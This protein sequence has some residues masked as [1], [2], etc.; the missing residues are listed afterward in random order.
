MKPS[1]WVWAER[2]TVK[3]KGLGAVYIDFLTQ[4]HTALEPNHKQ[5]LFWGDVAVNSPDLVGYV[6]KDMIA[7]PWRYE[8]SGFHPADRALHEG[9][10]RDMGCAGVNNWNRLYPNN[11]EALGNIRAFVRDGQKLGAQGRLNTVGTTTGKAY[12][13]RTGMGYCSARR[14]AGSQARVLKMRLRRR[15]GWRSMGTRVARSSQAQQELR[16]AH[17]LLKKAGLGDAQ[18]SYFWIDPFR[19]RASACRQDAARS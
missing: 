14:R 13:T 15:M 12:S 9:G 4:I 8:P 17:A 2:G 1:N 19:R 6:A 18:D 11:N 10:T 7:V 3:G 5:L 16:A